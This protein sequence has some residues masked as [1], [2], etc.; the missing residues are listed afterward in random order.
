MELHVA[1]FDEFAYLYAVNEQ[2]YELTMNVVVKNGA[3]T[4]NMVF[5][6][7]P[8]SHEQLILD[9]MPLAPGTV[10]EFIA[11]PSVAVHGHVLRSI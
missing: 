8:D 10:V 11:P 5:H 9:G 1:T 2:T 3:H 4:A 7:I 6:V